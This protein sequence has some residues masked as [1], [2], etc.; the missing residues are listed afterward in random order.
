MTRRTLL[1][2]AGSAL[3]LAACGGRPARTIAGDPK[4]IRVLTAALESER[5][6]VAFYEVGAKLTGDALVT[7]ILG[8]QRKHAAAI[9]EAIRELGGTPPPARP[10]AHMSLYRRPDAWRREAIKREGQWAA[11]YQAV[12][13]KLSNPPLRSTFGALMTSE[14]EY[15]AALELTA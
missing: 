9:E 2:S 12:I 7:Q 8:Y 11:G 14:A 15:A 4:D 13:P 6:Q 10:I 5:Q 1:L 3:L